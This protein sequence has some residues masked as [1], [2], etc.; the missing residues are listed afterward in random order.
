MVPRFSLNPLAPTVHW[1]RRDQKKQ[2]HRQRN[3]A[4]LRKTAFPIKVH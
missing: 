3:Q 2:S 1:Q 4:D